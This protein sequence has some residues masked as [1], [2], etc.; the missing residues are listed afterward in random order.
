MNFT[1]NTNRFVCYSARGRVNPRY[2]RFLFSSCWLFC[3]VS[4][5]NNNKRKID[6]SHRKC[7]SICLAWAST[8]KNLYTVC[9]RCTTC[10][11]QLGTVTAYFLKFIVKLFLSFFFLSLSLSLLC[12]HSRCALKALQFSLYMHFRVTLKKVHC[13]SVYSGSMNSM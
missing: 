8:G 2:I 13:N 12:S 10:H 3:F 9:T 4:T 7:V 11:L 6:L 1:M 5:N